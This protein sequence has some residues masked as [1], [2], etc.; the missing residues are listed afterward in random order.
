MKNVHLSGKMVLPASP[1]DRSPGWLSRAIRSKLFETVDPF[2][3]FSADRIGMSSNGVVHPDYGRSGLLTR[4]LLF[5]GLEIWSRGI[6]TFI[7]VTSSRYS[8]KAALYVRGQVLSFIPYATFEL[9]DGTKPLASVDM[10]DH[11]AA[12]LV[13]QKMTDRLIAEI[14]F[15]GTPTSK[16]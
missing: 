9:P 15:P 12:Y 13:G 3:T 8:T 7:G 14:M 16:L 4:S 6:D 11:K 2:A 10:E 1:E 5:M